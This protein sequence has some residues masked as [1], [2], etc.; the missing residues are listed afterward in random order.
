MAYGV[1]MR[2]FGKALKKLRDRVSHEVP[3]GPHTDVRKREI[4]P[5]FK[6]KSG[7]SR[8]QSVAEDKSLSP[9]EKY[10]R[11]VLGQDMSDKYID[12]RNKKK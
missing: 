1:A 8:L 5:S 2:G 6:K 4:N 3:T 12:P 9:K 11:D 7:R 10:K